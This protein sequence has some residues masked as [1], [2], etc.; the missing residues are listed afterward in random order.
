MLVNKM[1][2]SSPLSET[3]AVGTVVVAPGKEAFGRDI[4]EKTG[5]PYIEDIPNVSCSKGD[6][7]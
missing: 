3:A 6:F 5:R 2:L 7:T 1:M 4:V